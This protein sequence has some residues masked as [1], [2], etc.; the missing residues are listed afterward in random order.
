MKQH[1]QIN[2]AESLAL[3]QMGGLLG[4]EFNFVDYLMSTNQLFRSLADRFGED[5]GRYAEAAAV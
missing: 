4:A 5:A 3:R 1:K 2:D